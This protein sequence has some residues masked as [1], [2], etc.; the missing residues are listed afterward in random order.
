M[1]GVEASTSFTPIRSSSFLRGRDSSAMIDHTGL[2][3]IFVSIPTNSI[4]TERSAEKA[5]RTPEGQPLPDTAFQH[6]AAWDTAT[7]HRVA[8]WDAATFH[9]AA[10]WEQPLQDAATFHHVAAWDKRC[11]TMP[12]FTV[13]DNR[14]KTMPRFIVRPSG[15]TVVTNH[16][17]NLSCGRVGQYLQGRVGQDICKSLPHF[18]VW[19][20]G[21]RPARRCQISS[22]RMGQDI[23]K[24]LPHFIEF[25]H[26]D[27]WGT[28]DKTMDNSTW[29]HRESEDSTETAGRTPEVLDE[30]LQLHLALWLDG[31]VVQ[32][33]VEHDDGEGQ[34]EHRVRRLEVLHLVRVALAVPLRERLHQVKDNVSFVF[35]FLKL[36]ETLGGGVPCYSSLTPPSLHLPLI[37]VI[38]RFG[39]RTSQPLR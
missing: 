28:R 3:C 6:V 26:A 1:G 25:Y 32:V 12:H 17:H 15:T 27:V 5:G 19:P 8:A 33:G 7:F 36:G 37:P 20:R 35:V 13:W 18:I 34:Q 39:F 21:T 16:C 10:T 22:G 4:W 23:C 38:D 31:G 24:T 29:T 2:N 30:V 14:Y 9:R 11:K